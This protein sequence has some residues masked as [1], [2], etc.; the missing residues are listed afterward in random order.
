MKSAWNLLGVGAWLIVIA[1][2]IW[3]IY[4]IRKRRLKQLVQ[5]HKK[6]S[7]RNLI[8]S[9]IEVAVFVVGF[10]T[11]SYQTFFKSIDLTS[12]QTVRIHYR[13]DALVLNTNQQPS[14]FVSVKTGGGKNPL[15]TFTYLVDGA[16]YQTTNRN[17]S[18]SYGKRITDVEADAYPW[19]RKAL[20][21]E[22]KRTEHAFTAVMTATYKDNWQNGLGLHAGRHA[23]QYTLIRI[24]AQT[25]VH[26][27]N[28]E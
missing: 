9:L 7:T 15:Q 26:F 11:M 2:F 8:I 17:A 27:E 4:D 12:K 24:P 20:Q 10:C 28:K 5:T 19:D 21:R 18:I 6:F 13:Y 14:Y 25:F 23:T 22:D 16:E 1:F 3:M